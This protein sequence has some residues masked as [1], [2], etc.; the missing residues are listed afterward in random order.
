[1]W[2][3][4][5]QLQGGWWVAVTTLPTRHIRVLHLV[6]MCLKLTTPLPLHTHAHWHI[7]THTH[8]HAHAHAQALAHVHTHTHTHTLPF[9]GEGVL[10]VVRPFRLLVNHVLI[11][12]SV[13]PS[14]SPS[15]PRIIAPL[16]IANSASL[17]TRESSSRCSRVGN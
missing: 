15:G 17:Q 16:F 4:Q 5:C 13:M 2:P 3:K 9:V 14:V 8:S 6:R 12:C 1:M 10:G 11:L 7:H